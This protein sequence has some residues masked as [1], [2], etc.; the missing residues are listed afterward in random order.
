[1]SHP[2]RKRILIVALIALP[3]LLALSYPW[4]NETTGI[5]STLSTIGWIGFMLALL[6]VLVL[7][8]A[9]LVSS[10]GSRRHNTTNT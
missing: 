6:V 10:V 4:R 3:L 7:S 5:G 8:I 1:M 2:I 9:V